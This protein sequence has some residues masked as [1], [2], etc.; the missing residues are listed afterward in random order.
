MWRFVPSCIRSYVNEQNCYPD[1]LAAKGLQAYTLPGPALAVQSGQAVASGVQ[2][3]WGQVVIPP[4]ASP[5]LFMGTQTPVAP[6]VVD[7][8]SEESDNED[9]DT[10]AGQQQQSQQQQEHMQQATQPNPHTAH[11]VTSFTGQ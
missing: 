7:G 4:V 5:G 6:T 9:M 11:M 8:V 1:V 2:N 10:Q 3:D